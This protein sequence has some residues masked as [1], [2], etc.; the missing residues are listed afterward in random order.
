MHHIIEL[1]ARIQ[2]ESCIMD[3]HID[4]DTYMLRMFSDVSAEKYDALHSAVPVQNT[5]VTSYSINVYAWRML[6]HP[7]FK[8]YYTTLFTERLSHSIEVALPPHYR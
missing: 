7:E 5:E 8:T 3:K 1:K 2:R 6:N 4:L